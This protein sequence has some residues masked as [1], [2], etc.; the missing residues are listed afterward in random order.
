MLFHVRCE[1]S[2][3]PFANNYFYR[4]SPRVQSPSGISMH[5]SV[6]KYAN[7][8]NSWL[9]YTCVVNNEQ[10][11]SRNLL[12]AKHSH[13]VIDFTQTYLFTKGC[14]GNPAGNCSYWFICLI[15]GNRNSLNFTL[16]S[17]HLVI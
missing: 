3:I 9:L 12:Q 13:P 4:L 11:T 10:Y 5:P 17:D 1:K 16:N 15:F 7:K 6:H 8:K 14:V 2:A